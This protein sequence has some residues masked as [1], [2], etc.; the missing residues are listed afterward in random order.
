MEIKEQVPVRLTGGIFKTIH[1][2]R[3]ASGVR[4][5]RQIANAHSIALGFE[6]HHVVRVQGNGLFVFPGRKQILRQVDARQVIVMRSFGEQIQHVLILPAITHQ[7]VQHENAWSQVIGE[8]GS[9][10]FWNT[11]VEMNSFA[12]HVLETTLGFSV[13]ARDVDRSKCRANVVLPH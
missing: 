7:I 5:L 2:V 10:V 4:L 11:L 3:D 6:G 12:L 9:N 1:D 13:A 8:Q